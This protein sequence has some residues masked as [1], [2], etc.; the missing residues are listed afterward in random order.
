M[1][2]E[3]ACR[4]PDTQAVQDLL[5][6]L[7]EAQGKETCPSSILESGLVAHTLVQGIVIIWGNFLRE[8]TRILIACNYFRWS[9][10]FPTTSLNL[11][12]TSVACRPPNGEHLYSQMSLVPVLL[13][14]PTANHCTGQC[15][16]EGWIVRTILPNAVG[17][18]VH[19]KTATLRGPAQDGRG[20]LQVERIDGI[21][22]SH[23][24][25]PSPRHWTV[26]GFLYAQEPFPRTCRD[27]R[28]LLFPGLRRDG[29]VGRP[30]GEGRG[31]MAASTCVRSYCPLWPVCIFS[32]SS[33][34]AALLDKIVGKQLPDVAPT[35]WKYNDR[36]VQSAFNNRDSLLEMVSTIMENSQEWDT[37]GQ[38]PMPA[39][40]LTL[41]LFGL[42]PL[43][44]GQLTL[45]LFGQG[46]LPAGQLTLALFGQ[47]P[48]PAG[49]LTLALFGKDPLPAGQLTLAMRA[50]VLYLHKRVA[51]SIFDELQSGFLCGVLHVNT[52]SAKQSSGGHVGLIGM[53]YAKSIKGIQGP[54]SDLAI[55]HLSRHIG[56]RRGFA[57]VIHIV[58]AAT[59]ATAAAGMCWYHMQYSRVGRRELYFALPVIPPDEGV[60][61]PGSRERASNQSTVATSN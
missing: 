57:Y 9:P 10:P 7:T 50:P 53:G 34:R 54:E 39:G 8:L 42:G 37:F 59:I 22:A 36:L 33:K 25:I 29:R 48:L 40:Q 21:C 5:T 43:P 51:C 2:V 31:L 12:H 45:A 55:S 28:S 52:T 30:P 32:H 13:P 56:S 24:G 6:T 19:V 47:G 35:R 41:A 58:S 61:P 60:R 16:G 11:L 27:R 46:P 23:I 1:A 38:G 15:G 3:R 17:I 44:A 4:P 14:Q 18:S 20:R 49:Q 26:L